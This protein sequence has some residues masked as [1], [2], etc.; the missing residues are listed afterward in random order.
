MQYRYR[1]FDVQ[2]HVIAHMTRSYDAACVAINEEGRYV[3][4]ASDSRGQGRIVYR[5]EIGQD[6]AQAA[7]E[8]A[9]RVDQIRR[10]IR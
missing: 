6:V 10:G 3:T 4:Y 5:Y 7:T 9:S 2:D 8:I 1:V